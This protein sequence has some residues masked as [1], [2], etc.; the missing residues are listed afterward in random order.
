MYGK[1]KLFKK[2]RV[3]VTGF[4]IDP[5]SDVV[6]YSLSF[7]DGTGGG[8]GSGSA[9]GKIEITTDLTQDII[10]GNEI[11]SMDWGL[12]E[13]TDQS[14]SQDYSR[15]IT[16]FR[17]NM[18]GGTGRVLLKVSAKKSEAQME[19]LWGSEVNE[20]N[21]MPS[22]T[23]KGNNDGSSSAVPKNLTV[24]Q[25]NT[26]LGM[27]NLYTPSFING[28]SIVNNPTTPNS[29][30]DINIGKC[31]DSD[32]SFN[33][34]LDASITVDIG[35]SGAGGLDTGSESSD[36]WYAVYLIMD[37][38]EV[39]TAKGLF[40]L[41]SSS[42]TMPSGYDAFRRVG[43]VR[44]NSS[45][46]F[47][48]FYQVG[49]GNKK[50]MFYITTKS[51]VAVLSSGSATTFTTVNLSSFVPSTSNFVSFLYALDTF[52]TAGDVGFRIPGST[53]SRENSLSFVQP[54]ANTIGCQI[55]NLE[56]P[57]KNQE[58]EYEVD[59]SNDDMS[60]YIRGYIDDL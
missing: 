28:L 46:N 59:N 21:M 3:L 12:G 14:T 15:P 8:S 47:L 25:V 13:I 32:D 6:Y 16:A 18:T 34:I 22:L 10:D 2:Y 42:P 48:K 36:A 17:I 23:M 41:S 60:L 55:G 7:D 30:I 31:I 50:W 52:T 19:T 49:N 51:D 44:N 20:G 27:S 58:I 33:M 40:S 1:R 56:M 4:F 35:I 54:G 43:W 38:T 9:T 24:A 26:M 29:K 11:D 39:N 45:S 37:S 5:S 53:V 57:V